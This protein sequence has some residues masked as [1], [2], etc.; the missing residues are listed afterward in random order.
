MNRTNHLPEFNTIKKR[1]QISVPQDHFLLNKRFLGVLIE[2]SKLQNEALQQQ[3][4]QENNK[5]NTK[6]NRTN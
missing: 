3:L 1:I 2:L 4:N 5:T 6:N